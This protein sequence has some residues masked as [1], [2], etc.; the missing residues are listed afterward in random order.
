MITKRTEIL[1]LKEEIETLKRRNTELENLG[2]EYERMTG[3]LKESGKMY[4][5]LY[6][7][8]N[9]GLYRSTPDGGLIM[10]NPAM[11][12][13]LGYDSLDELLKINFDELAVRLSYPRKEFKK[14]MEFNTRLEGFETSLR[15]RDGGIVYIRESAIAVKDED[16]NVLYYEGT[17]EDI[18]EIKKIN[19][20]LE[21]SKIELEKRVKERTIEWSRINEQLKEELEKRKEIEKAQMESEEKFRILSEKSLVGIFIWQDG[22]FQYVNASFALMFAYSKEEMMHN[23]FENLVIKQDWSMVSSKIQRLLDGDVFSSHF[24]FRGRRKDRKAIFLEVHEARINFRNHPAIIGTFIDV[25]HMKII[26]RALKEK[27]EQ[28]E[29]LNRYLEQRIEAEIKKGRQQ[30]QILMQHS[31]LISMGEMVGAIAHQWRQPL[32]SIGFIIQ[33]LQSAYELNIF[34]EAYLNR[35]VEEAMTLIKFMSKTIDDFRNFFVISREKERFNIIKAIEEA[36]FLVNAQLVN[37]YIFVQ[38]DFPDIPGIY[39]VGFPNEFKQVILNIVSNARNAIIDQRNK[40]HSHEEKGIL[41]IEIQYLEDNA[42]IRMSNNGPL[43]PTEIIDRI[44]EPYF[45]TNEHGKGMGIGLYMSKII[46]EKNMNGRIYAENI[47]NEVVFTIE[48]K[49]ELTDETERKRDKV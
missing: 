2:K 15:R 48:L 28:L 7:N 46:I 20:A 34:S 37:N 23:N 12:K 36:L 3:T 32:T 5:S 6:D 21:N 29:D 10:A 31:K 14:M 45:T 43:I 17:V 22:A 47:N 38:L 39:V 16:G 24:Q 9:I 1:R 8:I 40:S 18:T 13:I 35:S 33:N 42:I 44:F 27:K 30:E 26:Q 4:R 11:A 19:A 25:T 49:G 41:Q